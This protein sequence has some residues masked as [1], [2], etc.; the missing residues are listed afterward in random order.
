LLSRKRK[1][2]SIYEEVF[3]H[4]SFTGR[5]GTFFAYEGLGS[6]YWHMVSKL[7]LATQECFFRAVNEGA[8]AEIIGQFKDHYYEIK[9]GIGLY[10]NP[11]LYG[12]FPMDAHSHTPANAGVKQPGLTGQVKEDVIARFGELA[13]TVINGSIVFDPALVNEDEILEKPTKFECYNLHG[14]P[15]Q[16]YLEKGQIGF[17]FCNTPIILNFSGKKKISVCYTDG[18][19]DETQ[20]LVLNH[21]IS[22]Q[23]FTRNGDD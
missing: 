22:N 6:I 11:E 3:D 17:T 12:A 4:Q 20:G 13:L 9:A 7:L 16:L 8:S 23:I 18:S 14:E 21:R 19:I 10:K 15:K 5:S 1:I 2:L